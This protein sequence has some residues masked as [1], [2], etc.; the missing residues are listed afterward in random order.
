[1]YQLYYKNQYLYQVFLIISK[2]PVVQC[3]GSESGSAWDP[4]PE[5]GK[6]TQKKEKK[7]QKNMKISIFYAVVFFK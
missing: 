3:F 7:G 1:M 4:D 5:D 2:V 6:T